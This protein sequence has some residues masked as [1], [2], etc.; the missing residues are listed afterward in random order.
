MMRR[1]RSTMLASN[2]LCRRSSAESAIESNDSGSRFLTAPPFSRRL[3][4]RAADAEFGRGFVYEGAGLALNLIARDVAGAASFAAESL[5]LAAAKS[6]APAAS[7]VIA[8]A[9]TLAAAPEMPSFPGVLTA[10]PDPRHSRAAATTVSTL[11]GDL[12]WAGVAGSL[13][14]DDA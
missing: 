4:T 14:G 1:S 11:E 6:Y 2:L 8:R 3:A 10:W 9:G 13:P 12:A 5:R 7:R